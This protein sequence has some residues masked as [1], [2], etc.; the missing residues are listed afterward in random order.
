MRTDAALVFLLACTVAS[1]CTRDAVSN[2]GE[3]R[4]LRV[5]LAYRGGAMRPPLPNPYLT[6]NNN[7][8]ANLRNVEG[9]IANSRLADL[10]TDAKTL[11]FFQLESGLLSHDIRES[12][13]EN[14]RRLPTSTD[15]STVCLG[16]WD[17][18]AIH[19]VEVHA[20]DEYHAVQP[21]HD[22]LNCFV[23][24]KRQLEQIASELKSSSQE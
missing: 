20:P 24:L 14:G 6:I 23:E 4:E 12:I 17:G 5:T 15:V 1:G 19:S 3:S 11:G 13:T 10:I 8:R 7:G 18:K 9:L 16:I 21:N 2:P 22:G